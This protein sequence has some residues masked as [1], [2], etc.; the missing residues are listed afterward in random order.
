MEDKRKKTKLLYLAKLFFEETYEDNALTLSEINE[1]LDGYGIKP[2]DRKT[3]Y[4]DFEE[5][6]AFGLDIIS[7]TRNGKG[8]Y[9]LGER[10]FE[11]PELKLLVD[12]VQSSRFMTEKKSRELISKLEKLASKAQAQQ[13]HRQVLISGRIKSMNES[14]YYNVD[15][16]NEAINLDSQIQ[17]QYFQWDVQKQMVKRHDGVKYTVSPWALVFDNDNYYLVG[18]EEGKIKHYRVDKMLNITS[19][20][21]PRLGKEHYHKEEYTHKSVFGMY[22]GD[23]TSVTVEAENRMAGIII[24][25]FG[26]ETP[27]IPVSK[28]RFQAILEVAVSQQF[29][30]WLIGLGPDIQLIGPMPVLRQM[31]ETIRRLEGQYMEV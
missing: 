22:G 23:I 24:D 7:E 18:Y 5:L 30:G 12:N 14:I 10:L 13:L 2:V 21:M 3:L 29:F 8:Y 17:F 15:R 27:M 16:I 19:T 26:L 28:T 4:G 6:R 20:G 11:L 9:F 25:R 31:K 1:R